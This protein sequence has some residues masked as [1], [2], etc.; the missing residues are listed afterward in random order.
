M[1]QESLDD[2]LQMYLHNG[3]S[4]NRPVAYTV[5]EQIMLRLLSMKVIGGPL[6][7]YIANCFSTDVAVHNLS[8]RL[9]TSSPFM[10]PITTV[11]RRNSDTSM[12]I[13]TVSH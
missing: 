5:V 8:N 9:L 11:V 12:E 7:G 3:Q 2:I 1:V 13:S 6:D 10:A 4:D